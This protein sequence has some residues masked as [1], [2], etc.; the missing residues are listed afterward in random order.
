MTDSLDK[1]KPPESAGLRSAVAVNTVFLSYKIVNPWAPRRHVIYP[2]R[3][4]IPPSGGIINQ[5]R[6]YH[7]PPRNP[8]V[9]LY[10]PQSLRQTT[11]ERYICVSELSDKTQS[12]ECVREPRVS[13]VD[14]VLQLLD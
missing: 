4:I 13:Y 5:P 8:W 14:P 3:L 12:S 10:V 7:V 6:V 2:R 1:R 9:N 11:G